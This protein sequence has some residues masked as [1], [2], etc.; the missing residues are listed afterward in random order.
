VRAASGSLNV[1]FETAFRSLNEQ[2]AYEAPDYTN[3]WFDDHNYQCKKIFSERCL[4]RHH[5]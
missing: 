3:V 5:V 1:V 4:E 2:P